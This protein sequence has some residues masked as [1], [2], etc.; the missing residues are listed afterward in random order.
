MLSSRRPEEWVQRA[1][2]PPVGR[3]L[4]LQ[5]C[6]VHPEKPCFALGKSMTARRAAEDCCWPLIE[7]HRASSRFPQETLRF[8]AD[9]LEPPR[10]RPMNRAGLSGLGYRATR[11]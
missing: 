8:V 6:T 5:P 2:L 3:N 1:G 4:S 10:P 7:P 11:Q 9:T